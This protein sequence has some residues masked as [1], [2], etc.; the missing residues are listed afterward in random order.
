MY[1]FSFKVKA[2]L[3]LYF[4]F[5]P[6]CH[7]D[8]LAYWLLGGSGEEENLDPS[9]RLIVLLLE[10]FRYDFVDIFDKVTPLNGFRRLKKNG[11]TAEYVIPVFPSNTLPNCH[12]VVT[13]LYTQYH[14]IV[15]D[16]I[17][18]EQ[19]E[20]IFS[21]D[22][23]NV[24]A[25]DNWWKFAEPI[26]ITAEKHNIK[27]ALYWWNGCQIQYGGYIAT[28]CES[29]QGAY[30][31]PDWEL[32][33]I[34]KRLN[35]V[36]DKFSNKNINL[37]MFHIRAIEFIGQHYGPDSLEMQEMI[38]KIDKI[39]SNLQDT[40]LKR[41][42]Q[43]NVVVMV[44]GDHGIAK[45]NKHPAFIINI[46][47][48]IDVNDIS[49]MFNRG[50]F[51]MIRPKRGKINKIHHKLKNANIN[52]LQVFLKNDLPENYK[53]KKSK[54][55]LPIIL[56]AEQGFIIKSIS[57]GKQIGPSDIYSGEHGYDPYKVKDM[58]TAFYARGPG[59]KHDYI[60]PP[61]EV[62][63]HYNIMCNILEIPC[64]PN[65]GSWKRITDVFGGES[66]ITIW[67]WVITIGAILLIVICGLAAG[68]KITRREKKD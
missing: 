39:I 49:Y 63:D 5:F 65:N 48:Y 66:D 37:A 59:I 21:K 42:L 53:I 24:K 22:S 36:L 8:L 6:V 18:D 10:G 1:L 4:L 43:K 68:Y 46:E 15:D 17:Y 2:A 60:I 7:C 27:S 31:N 28:K 58:R 16:F 14:G 50:S 3:V 32:H 11:V 34:Q 45:I 51:A 23:Y 9:T 35:D 41:K 33:N 44:I 12:S 29:P 57:D 61:I 56:L 40:I 19:S 62:V 67:D 30:E 26:W 64:L 20:Q 52:G 47:N 38:K 25:T 13:G 55:V 54:F